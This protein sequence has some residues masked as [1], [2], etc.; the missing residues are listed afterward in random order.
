MNKHLLI[1][2]FIIMLLSALFA[3][4]VIYQ[5]IQNTPHNNV[6][7]LLLPQSYNQALDIN[8]IVITNGKRRITMHLDGNF[9]HVSEADYYYAGLVISNALFLS[10]NEA[11]IKA[12]PQLTQEQYNA[13]QLGNPEKNEANPG[14]LIETYN[15]DGKK[16]ESIIIGSRNNHLQYARRPNSKQVWLVSG[17]FDL[18]ERTYSWLQQPLLMLNMDGVESVNITTAGQTENFSKTLDGQFINTANQNVN[19]RSLLEMFANLTFINVVKEQDFNKENINNQRDI[20]ITLESGLKHNIQIYEKHKEYW[21]K[22][23]NS[24]T[25]LPTKAASDYI[26]GSSFLSDGWIFQLRP[27]IGQ[28]LI[29]YDLGS[30]NIYVDFSR[31]FTTTN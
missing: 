2:G 16:L 23:K 6:G 9:W 19:L 22:L 21:I 15:K 26:K 24:T 1:Y 13:A 3:G 4:I 28:M 31:Q 25:T 30:D 5:R 27:A 29:N 11:A 12:L 7:D 17:N 10:F 18:P 20:S 8:K 14:N